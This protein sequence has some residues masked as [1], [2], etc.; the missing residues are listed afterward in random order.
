MVW[1]EESDGGPIHANRVASYLP[2]V[3]K[4]LKTGRE[5]CY[6]ALKCLL[7]EPFLTVPETGEVLQKRK[8]TNKQKKHLDKSASTARIEKELNL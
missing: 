7:T 5:Q 1:S 3:V 6:K 4:S 8:K 2:G